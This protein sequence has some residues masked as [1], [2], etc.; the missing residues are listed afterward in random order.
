MANYVLAAQRFLQNGYFDVP[1][2]ETYVNGKNYSLAYY[3]MHVVHHVR[4]G[5]E[6]LLAGIW[7]FSKHNGHEIYMPTII[8]LHLTLVSCSAAMVAGLTHNKKAPIIAAGL[9][10][11][12]PLSTLGVL[13]QLIAQVGGL[14]L[15]C[16]S[17]VL[18]FRPQSTINVL[19]KIQQFIILCFVLA[20]L[21]IWYPEGV[22]FLG[23][24]WL[25]YVA[26]T[27]IQTRSVQQLK[28]IVLP[29]I[30][31]G[32]GVIC[33]LGKYFLSFFHF[34]LNQAAGAR[35]ITDPIDIMFPFY[36]VPSG[37]PALWGF[38]SIPVRLDGRVI[39]PVIFIALLLTFWLVQYT[40]RKL[41]SYPAQTAIPVV[42]IVL[43]TMFFYRQSEFPLFKMA[44]YVQPFMIG[45]IAIW[46]TERELKTRHLGQKLT[47]AY[48]FISQFLSQQHYVVKSTGEFIGALLEI[49]HVS[50]QQVNRN[51]NKLVYNLR[52]LANNGLVIDTTNI[53]LAKFQMLYTQGLNVTFPS[54]NF[55]THFYETKISE[56]PTE[57]KGDCDFYM[58]IGERQTYFNL[59]AC[60]N[61]DLD[62]RMFIY[63]G[64]DQSVFNR[65]HYLTSI[66][67]RNA[68]LVY[69]E[70]HMIFLNSTIGGSYYSANRRRISFYQIEKDP[71]FDG[72]EFSAIG[73]Y[74]VFLTF[75]P[76]KKPRMVLELTTTVLKQFDHVLPQPTVQGHKVP[77]VGRGSGR[78]FSPPLDLT[79]DHDLAFVTVDIGRDSAQFP[80]HPKGLMKL[81]GTHIPADYRFLTSFSRDLS[82]VSEEEYQA[83][84]APTHLIQF[85]ND[86]A[87]RS[88]EY[89][90]VYEDGWLSE[91]CFFTLQQHKDTQFLVFKGVIPLTDDYNYKTTLTVDIGEG[92]KSTHELPIGRFE[93]K[94]PTDGSEG[95]K[96]VTLAFDNPQKFGGIDGRTV[97]ARVEF[98]GFLSE[99]YHAT[100]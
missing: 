51:F 13:Y 41:R 93:L 86:L 71:L 70:N 29:A 3:G 6:L 97:S 32:I 18:L 72:R 8:S 64:S 49:P 84:E 55:V 82:L 76:T 78:V 80:H 66:A 34:L 14:A 73:R 87:Q 98:I 15:V 42:M 44:M 81:Y 48:V 4:S 54:W 83:L 79:Y 57:L 52:P 50:S 45:V 43:W 94:I 26:M 65:F 28:A 77:F 75:K 74:M 69:P 11:I 40:F 36:L 90:G 24:G 21:L 38:L 22:P 2:P 67:N 100:H 58:N 68:S 20:T 7:A 63:S 91:S 25:I 89:S 96:K 59:A 27:A 56:K 16:A 12:S 35:V 5:S 53:A 60:Q 19:Q 85:P 62:A 95:R 92:K 30:L 39:S 9:M 88:L 99:P 1:D 61:L 33:F 37:I 31:A 46:L 47:L 23:C 17:S 10:A